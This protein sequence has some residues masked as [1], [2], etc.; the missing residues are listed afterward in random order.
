MND[1]LI[2][3]S[4]Q[5]RPRRAG[6]RYEIVVSTTTGYEVV[7]LGDYSIHE[8]MRRAARQVRTAGHTVI[9][10]NGTRITTRG[11]RRSA[12]RT[13]PVGIDWDAIESGKHALAYKENR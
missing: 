13:L 2:R 10:V 9:G 3:S 8:A 12:I 5:M 4:G 7:T 6:A 1:R 11:R